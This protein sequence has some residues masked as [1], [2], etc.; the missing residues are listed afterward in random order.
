MLALFTFHPNYHER[1]HKGSVRV[2]TCMGHHTFY[3]KQT[4]SGEAMSEKDAISVK[5]CLV[6]VS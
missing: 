3:L 6:G 1:D 5:K 2:G 4:G